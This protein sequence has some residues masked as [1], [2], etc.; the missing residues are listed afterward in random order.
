[1]A[2][3]RRAWL[4]IGAI[5]AATFTATCSGENPPDEK[6][7]E[8]GSA[9]G[10]SSAD[11]ELQELGN[12]CGSN[13]A[14]DF[15]QV[16]N[17]GTTSVTASDIT[18]KMWVD[19][20]SAA[21][22]VAAVY[23]GG[24]LTNSSGCFHQVSG[25]SVSAT[26]LA[27]ACGPAP[28]QQANWEITIS[29][30]DHT[31][32]AP[33][34]TWSNIQAALHLS[35]YG[36][37]NPGISDWY[38]PCVTGG[39]Y[40]D[41]AHFALYVQG[42]LVT[43]SA[44]VPPSCVA[45]QGMQP[46][47]GSVGPGVTGGEFPLV[48]PLPGSTPITVAISL[49]LT[50]QADLQSRLEQIYDPSSAF[51]HT[52]L[53]PTQFRDLY[54]PS[55]SDY[56]ALTAYAT[57]AGL[58]VSNTYTSRT[59]LAVTGPASAVESAFFVT[60]NQYKR[61]NGTVFYAPANDPSVNL[62]T[63]LLHI[64]GLDNF[65][66][67]RSANGS[68]P[69][70]GLNTSEAG[71]TQCPPLPS[72]SI[73]GATYGNDYIG[74]DFKRAYSIP[75]SNTGLGQVI[76]L[77]EFDSYD[78]DG[79]PAGFISDPTLYSQ[80]FLGGSP[81]VMQLPVNGAV[82]PGGGKAEVALN[83]EMALAMAPSAA[84][85][86]YEVQPYVSTGVS[87]AS[88]E[89][90]LAGPANEPD[91]TRPLV[92]ANTWT[93]EGS[94]ALPD[95]VIANHFLQYAVQGQSFFQAS[96][97]F[98]SYIPAGV[99]AGNGFPGGVNVPEPII[100]ST[101]MTVVGGT[102]LSTN[103]TPLW[104]G[105]EP[106]NNPNKKNMA[107]GSA[108][109]AVSGGGFCTGYTATT[110][111]G[112][113]GTV[114]PTL[115]IPSYQVGINPGNS[116]VTTNPLNARMIPDVS[117]VADQIAA[118]G[119]A[120]PGGSPANTLLTCQGG[121]SAAAPLWA[122]LAALINAKASPGTQIGFANQTL[123]SLPVGAFHDIASGDN[124]YDETGGDSYHAVAGYDLVTGLGTPNNV[125]GAIIA[126][127]LPPQSCL[128]GAALTALV[129]NV[130]Q[131]VTL[132]VPNG[133][134]TEDVTGVRVVPIEGSGSAM[135]IATPAA[136]NTCAGNS[137]TGTVVCT[138]NTTDVYL[139]S[140]TT[141]VNTLTSGATGTEEFSGGECETCNVAIDPV[142]NQAY[143]SVGLTNGAAIQPLNLTDAF[144]P[145]P[146]VVAMAMGTA[147]PTGQMATSEAI[148]V[149]GT[150]GLVLSPNEG[151]EFATPIAGGDYQLLNTTTGLVYD[152]LPSGGLPGG[153]FDSAAED[154]VTGIAV[155]ANEFT[156]Q[157]F[158]TDLTQATFLSSN[159]TWSA[160]SSFASFPEFS[161]LSAGTSAVV[162][163]STSHIG[164]VA[165]EFGGNAFGIFS[166]PTS[167]GTGTPNVQDWV[168]ATL[169]NTPDAQPWAM[170][171]DPHTLT[172]YTSPSASA[173]PY[174]VFQD[175]VSQ[176]GVRTYLAVVDMNA[177]LNTVARDPI[178]PPATA[179]HMISTPLTT[180]TGAGP[181]GT[182]PVAGCV[183][184]FV[185]N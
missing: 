148:G 99:T 78:P 135:T 9:I 44:G 127:L 38:S 36:N 122:G 34:V 32:M 105:E 110:E 43:A 64:A 90:L 2:D 6:T 168:V 83:V 71:N 96:G 27:T 178:V 5:A 30:T 123:Y 93:W 157:L 101:L 46:V 161:A 153:G 146:S 149:D 24:C 7:G 174:A 138:S 22:I 173:A 94:A 142:H 70:S 121:T 115:P 61:A 112:G 31:A 185:P 23:Y 120:N 151:F 54:G 88:I 158:L 77:L 156:N 167:G 29:N 104:V 129:N 145:T 143:L 182:P 136:V 170:G 97:D 166:L 164:A 163:V 35:N 103:G 116:E 89:L 55:Q 28:N 67:P 181:T 48:G 68:N 69:P 37:F 39:G 169:P 124:N 73:P 62:A 85:R 184:R 16:K 26:K 137:N 114:Y 12:S 91:L 57:A 74:E 75:T 175:D 58:T 56:D 10:V 130:A 141:L 119:F 165:G 117:M 3:K 139:I 86:V 132:Y 53:T 13:Q 21:S 134:W 150:R 128:P 183:V 98:G 144:S 4:H 172:A 113:M 133:S 118:Y 11:L 19:D 152:Y 59:V 154:C 25:V 51:Y 125:G 45:P 20:V 1:M 8:T 102:Q 177:L 33:G 147:I 109:A 84:V 81:N 65:T 82:T 52:Y 171:L 60:L 180:C 18:I 155:A 66:V 95:P 160:P 87:S 131:T 17:N 72:P 14:Q 126:G 108:T 63:P 41:P 76:G 176:N 100:D 140:G 159:S 47:P 42:N 50:N 111:S 92:I 107:A 179:S 106:W 79:T 80:K 49:P 15:F 40:T 162:V